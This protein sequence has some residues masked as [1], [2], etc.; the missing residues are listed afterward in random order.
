MLKEIGLLVHCGRWNISRQTK[1]ETVMINFVAAVEVLEA[2]TE[3]S[4]AELREMVQEAVGAW[5]RAD[6]RKMKRQERKSKK[7]K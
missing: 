7:V 1:Q 6:Y 3:E 2:K 4:I 5:S